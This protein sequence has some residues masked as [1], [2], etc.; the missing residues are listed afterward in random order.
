[1]PTCLFI[2]GEPGTGKKTVSDLLA[3]D[4]GWPLVWVHHFDAIYEAVGTHS[5]PRLTD[6]LTNAVV[7][8]VA[9]T[10]RDMIVC[11]PAR[12]MISVVH[13]EVVLRLQRAHKYDFVCV[14]LMASWDER[15]RRVI[16]RELSAQRA[17]TEEDVRAYARR[18]PMQAL[19]NEH[20]I[21][22][23]SKSPT[24]VAAEIKELLRSHQI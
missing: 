15:L 24:E 7:R 9:G 3:R 23:T 19:S 21:R 17:S 11:R 6:D 5:D 16:S 4:L 8:H 14:R 1:M 20:L 18:G 12:E 13:A 22:T 2:R 10:G